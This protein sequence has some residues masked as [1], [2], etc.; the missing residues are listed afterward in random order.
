MRWQDVRAGP[1]NVSGQVLKPGETTRPGGG[2]DKP[3][4]AADPRA[5]PYCHLLTDHKTPDLDEGLEQLAKCPLVWGW[6]VLLKIALN[7]MG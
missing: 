5:V 3:I 6:R 7:E 4:K 2:C 1:T